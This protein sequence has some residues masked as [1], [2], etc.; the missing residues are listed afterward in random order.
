MKSFTSLLPRL[1]LALLLF[2]VFAIL[3]GHAAIN[4]WPALGAWGADGLR[5]IF[6]DPAVAELETIVFQV[7]DSL[8]RLRTAPSQPS[9]SAP[10]GGASRGTRTL[11]KFE[12]P[13]SAWFPDALPSSGRVVGEGEW[14]SYLQTAQGRTVAYQTFL[15]PDSHRA[16]AQATI[17]AFNLNATRL[18]FVLGTDEPHSTV[19]LERSGRIP[20]VDG[21]PGMLLAVLNGGFKARHGNFGVMVNGVTLLPMRDGLG[22][23]ATYG[24]DGR[25]RIGPWGEEIVATPDLVAARQNGPLIIH[26]GVIN[27]Y[28]EFTESREWGYIVRNNTATWRSGLGLSADGRT[29]YYVVGPGLTL[30]RLA[31]VLVTAGAA[32]A[33]QL[34]LNKAWVYAGAAHVAESKMQLAPLLDF[35]PEI[36]DLENHSFSRDFF[37]ITSDTGPE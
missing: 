13:F 33:L 20:K 8:V 29:L 21:Q 2:V 16:Y 11:S 27:P 5:A 30:S 36:E 28:T 4:I 34:D 3:G 24:T 22:T 35:M 7:Q 26:A 19:T 15:L 12:D 31:E 14:V 32:E 25:V 17:L 1:R 6:G 37:Y 18:H 23:V 10:H 9:T